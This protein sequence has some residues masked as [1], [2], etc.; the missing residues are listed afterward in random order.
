M[1]SL[2]NKHDKEV[3]RE[4]YTTLSFIKSKK[5]EQLALTLINDKQNIVNSIHMLMV[6]YKKEY[7][8]LLADV[9]ILFYN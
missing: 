2:L 1:F 6:N 4:I 9:Y 3:D 8:E 7:K 5:V